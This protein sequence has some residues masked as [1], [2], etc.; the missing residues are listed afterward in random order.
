MF[1]AN[2]KYSEIVMGIDDNCIVVCRSSFIE[3]YS[4]ERTNLNALF[5]SSNTCA[6]FIP[7]NGTPDT[8]INS[9]SICICIEDYTELEKFKHLVG[10]II[11]AVEHK[12]NSTRYLSNSVSQIMKAKKTLKTE[13]KEKCMSFIKEN[14]DPD[15]K[16]KEHLLK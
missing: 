5:Q 7:M 4:R 2:E 9:I 16:S 10:Y 3:H 13:V 15:F 1:S 6:T 12:E 11:N 14:P 8:S